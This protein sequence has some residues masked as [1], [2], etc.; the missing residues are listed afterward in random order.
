MSTPGKSVNAWIYLAEDDPANTSY[1]SPNS[2]YQSLIN[3]GVYKY[4]DMVNICFFE[5]V[6]DQGTPGSY[7]IAIESA[8][9]PAPYTNQD[10][11]N[12]M[13]QDAR[14]ANPNIKI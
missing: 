9:H 14:A 12:M 13:I 3:F 1:K 11:M 2:S 8:S 5:V 10:Y 6:P 4:V 7:T